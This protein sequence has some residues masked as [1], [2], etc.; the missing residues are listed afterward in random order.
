MQDGRRDAARVPGYA[1]ISERDFSRFDREG[2][3]CHT[4]LKLFDLY[5][6]T[7]YFTS[8][9]SLYPHRRVYPYDRGIPSGWVVC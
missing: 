4:L 6:G 5:A 7:E 2:Y 3:Y 9:R 1:G 8:G